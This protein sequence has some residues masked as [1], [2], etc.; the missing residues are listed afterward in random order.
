M[1]CDPGPPAWNAL[2]HSASDQPSNQATECSRAELKTECTADWLVVGAGFTGLSCARRLAQLHPNDTIVVL[3]ASQIAAGP[4][5]RNSG[6]MIDVPHV[7]TTSD[8]AG[9]AEKDQRDIRLN[10]AGIDYALEAKATYNMP[11]EAATRSGKING[12][13]TKRGVLH[14][15][16]YAKYLDALSEPYEWLNQQQMQSVTGID[17]YQQ[18]LYTAGTVML[19]P[20]MY[21]QALAA[22]IKRDGVRIYENSPVI[23][24]QRSDERWHAVTPSGEV[25]ASK[26][27]LTVNGHLESFGF[28]QRQLM[29]VFTYASMTRALTD[30]EVKVLGGEANWA[31]TPADT[32]G[33][34]VRRVSGVG[35]NRI[36]VR[37]RATFDPTLEVDDARIAHVAKDHDRSYQFRFP[38]LAN[39]EMEYRWG[40]RLCLSR[41]NV[42]VFGELEPGLF[43]ACCQNGLGT[44]K[45]TISGK[46]IAEHASGESSSL[47]QDQLADAPAKRLPPAPV[48]AIG[49]TAKLRWGEWRAGAEL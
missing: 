13:I 43:A 40:G 15:Q 48:A 19:Q 4:A 46:L 9:A 38:K 21:I 34:T 42:S 8:Y 5:G 33:T 11:E 45:G 6:F 1:P 29:H 3:E 25:N 12:A 28:A 32:L 37:N 2:L 14:N 27:I 23:Q 47:L 39:V 24:L 41:N 20:A 35:G 10:R 31:I 30:D 18:G 36:V 22:G 49:A 26:V 17:C 16:A 7:L 44:A